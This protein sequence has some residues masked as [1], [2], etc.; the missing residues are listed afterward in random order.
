MGAN[1]RDGVPI[2]VCVAFMFKPSKDHLYDLTKTYKD[3]EGYLK[4]LKWR[5]R[6]AIRHACSEFETKDFQTS[7]ATVQAR[8][9]KKL[10]EE[11]SPAT[12]RPFKPS[13]HAEIMTLNFI[14]HDQPAVYVD[15]ITLTEDARND[16]A[17][18]ETQRAMLLTEAQTKLLE[19][20]QAANT[21]LMAA[22]REASV[23]A[24]YAVSDAAKERERYD[25]SRGDAAP[26]AHRPAPSSSL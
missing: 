12:E 3:W 11:V 2:T 20:R 16:I 8:M 5:S 21:T 6:S 9:E 7:R 1:T 18:A 24:A 17:L 15:A 19:A 26:R 25:F 13:M 22:S 23:I 10:G 14:S 4:V